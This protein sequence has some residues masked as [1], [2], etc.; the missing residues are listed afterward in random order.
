MHY[1][2]NPELLAKHSPAHAPDCGGAASAAG[3]SL[4][5]QVGARVRR[6]VATPWC[7]FEYPVHK[8]ASS[9]A[10]PGETHCRCRR[11]RRQVPLLWA[12][13]SRSRRA[14]APRRSRVWFGRQYPPELPLVFAGHDLWPI[15]GADRADR[16]LAGWHLRWSRKG[17]RRTGSYPVSPIVHDTAA[18]PR[19]NACPSWENRCHQ[20]SMPESVLDSAFLAKHN[21]ELPSSLRRHS[22]MPWPQ[23]D[24]G[25]GVWHSP[26]PEQVAPPWAQHFSAQQAKAGPCNM[27]EKVPPCLHDP[28]RWKA[29]P[30]THETWPRYR[31]RVY[32]SCTQHTHSFQVFAIYL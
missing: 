22:M 18:L 17:T 27:T 11:P 30:H 28:T 15:L 26:G 29:F 16:L 1:A 7:F 23:N 9:D 2:A 32:F 5:T 10:H 8:R 14:V 13:P 24:A 25:I 3:H 31:V 21:L 20:R 4:N 6:P 19:R 12:Y